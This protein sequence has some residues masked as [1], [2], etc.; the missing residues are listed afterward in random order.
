M[1]DEHRHGMDEF[2]SRLRDV[3][4]DI[5]VIKTMADENS[6]SRKILWGLST[7]VITLFIGGL[8]SFIR[9][10]SA[11]ENIDM[12]G[13][14]TDMHTALDVLG[15][16]GNELAEIRGEQLR[17]RVSSDQLR[18]EMKAEVLSRTKDRY[19]RSDWNDNK[20]MLDAREENSKLRE[21]AINMRLDHLEREHHNQE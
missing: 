8:I 14:N 11:V 7:L 6:G 3:E 10:E 4:Q 5:A 1:T 9:L 15:Q 17:M 13:L 19:Y 20:E 21:K 12:D 16:H 18:S 2:N